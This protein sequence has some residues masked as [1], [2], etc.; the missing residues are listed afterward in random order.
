[1]LNFSLF[2]LLF[3][4]PSA[5]FWLRQLLPCAPS[6]IVNN[7]TLLYPPCA[8]CLT[9][10]YASRLFTPY[11]VFRK[12]EKTQQEIGKHLKLRINFS[13]VFFSFFFFLLC[14]RLL[15]FFLPFCSNNNS[16]SI[17]CS[18]YSH[19]INSSNSDDSHCIYVYNSS[20]WRCTSNFNYN[21]CSSDGTPGW[22]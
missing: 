20:Y 2:C 6:C 11:V 12:K 18:T 13:L 3:E 22:R 19:D 5:P 17:E 7:E 1:M 4:T 21:R 8:L 15:F 14:C 10:L 9:P 16:R